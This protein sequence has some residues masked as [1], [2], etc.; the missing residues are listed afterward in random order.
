MRNDL[1]RALQA[2]E[3]TGL[4]VALVENNAICE[5]YVFG[6]SAGEAIGVNTEWVVAS[7][8]KPVF[9]Y[10]VLQLAQQGVI[11]L[12]R[13]LQDYLQTPYVEGVPHLA[14]ITARHC[15]MHASG[16][17]NWRNEHGLQCAFAPGER[18]SYSSE[19]LTYL[20]YVVEHVTGL[21]MVELLHQQVFAPLSM[22]HSRLAVERAADLPPMLHFLSGTLRAN[23]ALSLRTTIEDYALFIAA[24]FDDTSS[25]TQAMLRTEIKVG[26][27]SDLS[28]GLG[29]GL[30]TSLSGVSF[31]HWGARGIP[32]RMNFA[33][34][35]PAR[36]RG[37]VI[38]TDHENGLY[39]CRSIIAEWW[40][41]EP[42]LPAFEWLLPA[43]DWRPDGKKHRDC[44]QP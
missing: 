23:G 4:A 21:P 14:H 38:F 8:T 28:W 25:V 33:M 40:L 1:E 26:N 15:M 37:I 22:A 39:L 5:T 32:K 9:V 43:M 16:L 2:S 19:G 34:G 44:T 6:E 13:P 35:I 36:R 27:V 18:F 17:P 24:M 3:V 30:Q 11:D 7:L 31:W 42:V 10:G 29:W 41:K 20:Q 12:D